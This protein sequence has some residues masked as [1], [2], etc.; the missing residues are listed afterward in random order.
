VD[1]VGR[2]SEKS[3][4]F[5]TMFG[6]LFF[7]TAGPTQNQEVTTSKIVTFF[8]ASLVPGF[9]ENGVFLIEK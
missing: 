7:M 2:I 8:G 3:D 5:K 4:T 1:K 6:C 9:G